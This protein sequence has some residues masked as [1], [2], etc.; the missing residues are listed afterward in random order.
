M[1]DAINGPNGAE[2][3]LCKCD[4]CA[5]EVTVSAAHGD[6]RGGTKP[7]RKTIRNQGQ[8]EIKLQSLGWSFVKKK[9]RCPKCEAARKQKPSWLEAAE[10]TFVAEEISMPAEVDNITPLR[11]PTREHIRE[12]SAL[13]HVE[14]DTA[15]QRYRGESTDKS[16]A[17]I[18]GNGCMPGWVAAERIRGFGENGGNEAI[19]NATDDLAALRAALDAAMD[20]F[21]KSR[22]AAIGAINA[23]AA[24]HAKAVKPLADRIADLESRQSR[25]IKAIG[26]KAGGK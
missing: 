8:V 20:E 14:Y 18:V 15:A 19:A 6:T 2:M 7:I 21:A 13:L 12:I 24:A 16:I 25:I 22:D 1:I 10:Q 4:F 11:Q 26:P 17:D 23:A 5:A 9:L 3:A